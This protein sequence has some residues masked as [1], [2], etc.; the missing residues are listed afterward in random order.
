MRKACF[1]FGCVA[2]IT[3]TLHAVPHGHQER[4]LSN[5]NAGNNKPL[6]SQHQLNRRSSG[7]LVDE[8][9]NTANV[10]ITSLTTSQRDSATFSMNSN[11][12]TDGKNVGFV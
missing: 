5:R 2:S 7:E 8:M 1:L 12:F 10:L 4:G 3:S 6:A 9:V 11:E